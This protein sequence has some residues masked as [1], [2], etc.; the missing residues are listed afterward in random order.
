MLLLLCAFVE[1]RDQIVSILFLL[2]TGEHHLRAGN[3]LLGVRQ[4][5]VQSVRSPGDAWKRGLV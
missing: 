4:I 5:L 1:E 3:V 2:E